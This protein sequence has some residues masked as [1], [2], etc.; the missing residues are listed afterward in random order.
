M[1]NP[2]GQ[3]DEGVHNLE[4]FISVLMTTIEQ[5]KA[6]TTAIENHGSTVDELDHQAEG[7]LSDLGGALDDLEEALESG[8]EDAVQEIGRLRDEAHDGAEQ[9]MA[10]AQS[11]LEGAESSFD[12]A[13]Q[14][15]HDHLQ[16]ELGT[17]TSDGFEQ[18]ESTLENVESG[19]AEDR[20]EAEGAFDALDQGVEEM[21]GKAKKAFEDADAAFDQTNSELANQ[22]STIT[23][24]GGDSVTAFDG[25]GDDIDNH[26]R[27]MATALEGT[28]DGWKAE[29]EQDEQDLTTQVETLLADAGTAVQGAGQDQ[30]DTPAQTTLDDGLAPYVTE[31]VELQGLIESAQGPANDE[32]IPLVDDLEKALSVIGTI[33]ELLNALE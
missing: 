20:Q 27:T 18:L 26:C 14:E 7:D 11:A 16:E 22:K 2:S 12:S 13:M 28:C 6:H 17:L 30:L 19:L 23:T 25:I 1:A 8:E 5:V 21:E 15:G 10:E 4:R 3:L 9:T 32:L 29:V 33:D 31:L 24:D